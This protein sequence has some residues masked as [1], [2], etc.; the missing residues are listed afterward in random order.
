MDSFN[1]QDVINE[2]D[3]LEDIYLRCK[4]IFPAMRS[5][6]IGLNSI[7]ATPYYQWRGY[8][9]SINLDQDISQDFID[10][11]KEIGNWINENVIIR[12]YGVLKYYQ[13]YD[14]QIDRDHPG[15]EDLDILRR[16]RDVFT[17][18]RLNYEPEDA[19]NIKLREKVIEHYNLNPDEFVEGEIPTTVNTV[20]KPIFEKARE[21]VQ[22]KFKENA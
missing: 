7:Q 18:T 6:M 11:Y 9:I 10:R 19:K 5:N 4:C 15:W 8:N 1:A 16:V 13:C 3:S 17:K 2:I 22:S 12:L 21:H 20:I 14:P